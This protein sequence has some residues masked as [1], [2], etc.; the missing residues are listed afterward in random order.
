MVYV[1]NLTQ[2]KWGKACIGRM[3]SPKKMAR[4]GISPI[5]A[6]HGAMAGG[7]TSQ[8]AGHGNSQ[9]GGGFPHSEFIARRT[10]GLRWELLESCKVAMVVMVLGSW[11]GLKYHADIRYT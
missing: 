4:H 6:W 5:Q 1:T 9:E 7:T 8:S 2:Q 11:Y 3:S 10:Y